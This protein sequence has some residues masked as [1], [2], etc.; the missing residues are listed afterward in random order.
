MGKFISVLSASGMICHI[1]ISKWDNLPRFYQQMGSWTA[2]L[3]ANGMIYHVSIR[4]W[5]HL[6]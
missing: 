1:S 4:K 2:F 3:S 5:D 6:R